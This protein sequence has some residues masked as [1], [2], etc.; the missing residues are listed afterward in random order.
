MA[1]HTCF[2]LLVFFPLSLFKLKARTWQSIE[3]YALYHEKRVNVW[4]SKSVTFSLVFCINLWKVVSSLQMIVFMD[5][6]IAIIHN[7]HDI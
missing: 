4:I 3:Q 5:N 6:F 2:W 7:H 1:Q